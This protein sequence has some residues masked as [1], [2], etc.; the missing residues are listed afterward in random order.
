MLWDHARQHTSKRTTDAVASIGHHI[1]E[2]YPAQ[3]CDINIIEN[4]WGMLDQHLIRSK[5]GCTATWYKLIR[6]AWGNFEWDGDWSEKSRLWTK[7]IK[8]EVEWESS[9]N[10][11]F[12]MSIE[13]YHLNFATTIICKTN[14]NY[15]HSTTE[16]RQDI[17]TESILK[18]TLSSDQTAFFTLSQLAFRIVPKEYNYHPYN[19]KMI[20][21]RADKE[22]KDFPLQYID[23]IVDSRDDMSIE[24]DLVAGEYHLFVEVDWDEVRPHDS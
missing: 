5:A 12:Y 6:N 13:D 24:A 21:A 16:V 10:G 18:F 7:S 23:A 4:C 1:L 15:H 9:E 14:P 20:L 19:A 22:N 2:G 3:C 17:G 11:I 8:D